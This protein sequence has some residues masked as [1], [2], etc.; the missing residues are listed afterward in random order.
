[1]FLSVSPST[2]VKGERGEGGPSQRLVVAGLPG[3][4]DPCR[5][6]GGGGG[7]A[8]GDGDGNNQMCVLRGVRVPIV[9]CCRDGSRAVISRAVSRICWMEGIDWGLV[10]S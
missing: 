6:G 5:G 4:M 2:R 9:G 1:M 10:G 3:P 7:G 8:S